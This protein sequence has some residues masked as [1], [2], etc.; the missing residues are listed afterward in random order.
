MPLL[1]QK[2]INSYDQWAITE[3][4]VLMEKANKRFVVG[5][6]PVEEEETKNDQ[7]QASAA[8]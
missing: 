4:A 7:R 5:V 8:E 3:K 2:A 6:I 1:L